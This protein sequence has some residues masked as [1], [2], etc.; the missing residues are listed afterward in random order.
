MLVMYDACHAHRILSVT[1][2]TRPM[3]LTPCAA[4]ESERRTTGS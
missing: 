4:A 3:D 2:A 1:A